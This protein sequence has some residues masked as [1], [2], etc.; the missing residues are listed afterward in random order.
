MFTNLTDSLKKTIS[1]AVN[2]ASS[3]FDMLKMLKELHV[4]VKELRKDVLDIKEYLGKQEEYARQMLEG[5]FEL[6]E[7]DDLFYPN[8]DQNNDDD[9]KDMN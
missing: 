5:S 9:D 4:E 7:E 8:S 3:I 2:S 1:S 6:V